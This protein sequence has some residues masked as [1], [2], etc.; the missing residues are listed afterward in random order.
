[1]KTVVIGFLGTTLDAGLGDRRWNKWR[2][3]VALGQ[4]EDLVVDRLELVHP[5]NRRRLAETVAADV[6]QV[7]PETEVRLHALDLR[8]P[9]D[10]EEVFAGLHGFARSLTFDEER[11]RYLVHITT[12]TH[13][14]Q[15]CFF[16]LTES[17]HFPAT[18]LQTSPPKRSSTDAAGSFALIDLDRS[19][20][21]ALARRFAEEREESLAFLKA[22]IATRSHKREAPVLRRQLARQALKHHG[23]AI[24]PGGRH[25]F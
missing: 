7:S 8:D 18:L 14:A 17:R 6:R 15:I 20:Y 5:P 23:G 16:L 11:E 22:G 1:M 13:V 9:W 12:G 25:G 3:T 24:L 21:D 10:F 2:P 4:H 19:R